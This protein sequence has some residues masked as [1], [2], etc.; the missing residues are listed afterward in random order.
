M[1]NLLPHFHT[2][3]SSSHIEVALIKIYFDAENRFRNKDALCSNR[4]T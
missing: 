4:I 3:P 2:I 1:Q